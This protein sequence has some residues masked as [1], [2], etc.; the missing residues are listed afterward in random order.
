[1]IRRNGERVQETCVRDIAFSNMKHKSGSVL[2]NVSLCVFSS[3]AFCIFFFTMEV[4]ILGKDLK[5]KMFTIYL[6]SQIQT[7]LLVGKTEDVI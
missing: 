5:T 1:M 3:L 2:E 6:E 7:V 4:F